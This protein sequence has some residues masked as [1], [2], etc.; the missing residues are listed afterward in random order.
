MGRQRAGP[1]CRRV[2]AELVPEFPLPVRRGGGHGPTAPQRAGQPARRDSAGRHDPCRGGSS[3]RPP[4]S[5]SLRRRAPAGTVRPGAG[6]DLAGPGGTAT[7]AAAAAGRTHLGARSQVSA[8]AA[9][10]GARPRRPPY[11]RA[12]GAARPQ[13]GGPLRRPAG[14]AGAGQSDGRRHPARGADA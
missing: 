4:L 2:A 13:S 5:R 9:H 1:P 8:P 11:R 6:P 14:D 3:G 7:S 10:H 12:G